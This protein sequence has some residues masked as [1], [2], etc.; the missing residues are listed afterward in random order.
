M[1]CFSHKTPAVNMKII[2][3]CNTFSA[4]CV[5]NFSD[6]M[7]MYHYVLMHKTMVIKMKIINPCTGNIFSASCVFLDL[8]THRT[9]N[10]MFQA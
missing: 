4:S 3:P 2:N 9:N 10:A 6:T 1:L 7:S 5:D 8:H